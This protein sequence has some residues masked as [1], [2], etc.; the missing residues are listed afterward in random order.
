[1]LLAEVSDLRRVV[2]LGHAARQ[3]AGL[4][5]QQP[6]RTLVVEGAARAAA[7][8][9]ELR[10]EL[11]VKEVRFEPVDAELRVKPNLPVLGPRLGSELADV[12]AALQAG[13]FDDLGGGRFRVGS[14]ELEPDEVLVERAGKDGWSVAGEDGVTVALDTHVDA[15]LDVERRVYELIRSVNVLRKEQGLEISD[16]IVL[17]IAAADLDLLEHR[18]WIA[19]ETLAISVE[20]DSE[21]DVRIE[22]AP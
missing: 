10:E 9:D 17:R 2:G 5:V 21:R 14:H 16:R 20:A 18:D 11:R 8:A 3:S 22:R 13:A 19:R 15:E 6:L 4:K 1:V 12:R 7:H